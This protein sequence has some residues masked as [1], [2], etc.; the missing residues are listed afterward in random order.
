MPDLRRLLPLLAAVLVLT[1][2][3]GTSSDPSPA[4]TSTG[5]AFVGTTSGTTASPGAAS[6]TDTESAGSAAGATA[7]SSALADDPRLDDMNDDGVPD[8]S[9]GTQDFG[10]GL[11]L[12]ISCNL[13]HA[14][15][16][17]AGTRL[18]AKSLYRLN[19]P[20]T[21]LT[22]I[23][24]ELV[25]A[26]DTAG[27]RVFILISNSD[28][29]FDTGSHSIRS[30]GTLEHTITFINSNVPGGAVQV[31]GHTDHTGSASANT[32]LSQQRAGTV[33]TYLTSHQVRASSVA[34]VGLGSSQPLVEETTTDGVV[35]TAGR[36]FNRRVEIVIRLHG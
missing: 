15:T 21:D 2:C 14:H 13:Q 5:G 8:P 35:S 27:N 32:T 11:V 1:G 36:A 3:Q 18:V 30:T 10:A 33:A 20:D 24:G 31:R 6:A 29:L 17:E 23:S 28:A 25:Y 4:T 22:G 34:A 7:T 16:P 9:C 26:R 12:R 19:G